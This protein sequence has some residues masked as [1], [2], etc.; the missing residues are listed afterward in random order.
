VSIRR[1]RLTADSSERLSLGTKLG[2]GSGDIYGGG[3]MT[4]VGFLYL[5]FLTDVI[6][7]SP[8]LAGVVILVS[9]I[10]DA[11]SDPVMGTISDRT[12][13]RWGR[14]RPYFLFGIPLVFLSFLVLW[15]PV[16]FEA[17]AARFVFVLAAYLLFSTVITLVMVPYNALSSELTT[18]YDERT[19]LSTVRLAFST[20][21]SLLCAVVPLELI[22]VVPD[23]RTGYVML[24]I[25]FGLF[26]ALPFLAVFF[27]TR[28]RKEFQQ[29]RQKVTAYR[30]FVEPFR[31]KP[32][33]HVLVMYLFAFVAVDAL[34]AVLIY[35]MTYYIGRGG[36]ANYILGTLMVVQLLA[37]PLYS[38]I[39]RKTS[40]R[41]SYMLGAG[42][43]A[44]AMSLSLLIGPGQPSFVIYLFAGLVGLA[45]SGVVVMIYAIFPDIPDIDE[46]HSG[47]RREG[48]YSGLFTFM[49]KLSSAIGLFIISNLIQVAGYQPP[50]ESIVNGVATVVEHAQSDQFILYLRLIF[51]VVPVVFLV[52]CLIGARLYRLTPELHDR[53][54]VYLGKRRRAGSEGG[55][56]E[57]ADE[58]RALR[59]AL[60]LP[61]R[62]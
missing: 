42:L 53:L 61:A 37:L 15:Y 13:S 58:E 18:D 59:E 16:S 23:Q 48:T 34:Q 51:F 55:S 44:I 20:V 25:A 60:Q 2:F 11:V 22:K 7:I 31:I 36:E 38:M 1:N 12:R 62:Q 57:D 46:L 19:R 17:E 52:F 10:W 8:A 50:T 45:T 5:F 6:R 32:F 39:S 14:R 24:G 26:F 43:W 40:K 4:I 49:R 41:F 33:R 56:Y 29:T 27:T 35:Y 3:A 30:M 47:E 28:E 9:K 54:R 21:A